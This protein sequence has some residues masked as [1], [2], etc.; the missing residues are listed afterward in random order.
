[1]SVQRQSWLFCNGSRPRLD[2]W[3]YGA[4]SPVVLERRGIAN[5]RFRRCLI[6]WKPMVG[7]PAACRHGRMRFPPWGEFG[8]WARPSFGQHANFIF[9]MLLLCPAVAHGAAG[10]RNPNGA[11]MAGSFGFEYQ[12]T[13][14]GRVQTVGNGPAGVRAGCWDV[15]PTSFVPTDRHLACIALPLS[16]SRTAPYAGLFRGRSKHTGEPR[17]HG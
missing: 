9:Q 13:V 17:Y 14:S 5:R 16:V 1:M 11:V 4:L 15:P 8:M 7:L 12:S 10:G 6:P 2:V 3:S